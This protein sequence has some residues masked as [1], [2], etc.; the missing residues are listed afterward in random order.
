MKDKAVVEKRK[1]EILQQQGESGE[2]TDISRRVTPQWYKLTIFEPIPRHYFSTQ[3]N[4]VLNELQGYASLRDPVAG[5]EVWFTPANIV[6]LSD[7]GSK[8]PG[9]R[10]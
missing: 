7:D 8:V 6:G 1:E 4:Y 2:A 10:S 9:R 3:A 5:I